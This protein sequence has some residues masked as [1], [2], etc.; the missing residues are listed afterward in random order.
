M[1]EQKTKDQEAELSNILSTMD[2]ETARTVGRGT[3]CGQWLS[4]I[5]SRVNGTE[6]S[7]LEFRDALHMRY[8]RTPG[9]LP[10]VC[11]GCKAKFTLQ[12]ALECKKG[13]LVT[14]RHDELNGEVKEWCCKALTPS[15]VR[16]EPLIQLDSSTSTGSKAP[17]TPSDNPPASPDTDYSDH[18]GKRGD[19]LVRGLFQRGMDCIIDVRVTDLDAKSYRNQDPAKVLA[20]QEKQKKSKYLQECLQQRRAFVP[21]VVSTDGML[22]YEANNLLRQV[23][24]KLANKWRLPYSKVCSIVRT[25]VGIAIVRA[26][27]L[28]LRGSRQPASQ[29]SRKLLWEDGAG[30]GLMEAS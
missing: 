9:N 25:R 27:H 28:C 30:T 3:E 19:L 1:K 2:A 12:H 24:R 23:S 17:T 18:D 15:A 29:I 13:G 20:N 4:A 11:D 7:A 26:T 14:M 6:L 22:G 5:P 16:V 21:F 10:C 8:G